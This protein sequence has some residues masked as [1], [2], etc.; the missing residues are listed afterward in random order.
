MPKEQY[1]TG[2]PIPLQINR[3]TKLNYRSEKKEE[4][5]IISQLHDGKD[6]PV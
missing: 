3:L 5:Y 6:G 1:K 2:S 4:G